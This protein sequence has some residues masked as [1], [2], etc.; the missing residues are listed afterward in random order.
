MEIEV[1]KSYHLRTAESIGITKVFIDYILDNSVNNHPDAKLIV[2]RIWIKHKRYWKHYVDPY[3]V[4]CIF[5]D[6]KYDK[7]I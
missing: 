1:G 7:E 6:W 5:N 3:Y 2:Y 4:L